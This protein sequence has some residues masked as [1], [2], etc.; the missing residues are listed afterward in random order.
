[1]N[2]LARRAPGVSL[3]QA[4][5]SVKAQTSEILAQSVPPRFNALR[6]KI[7][8]RHKLTV[9]EARGGVDYF[10]RSRFG[11]PLYA[12][13]GL[14]AA[15][16][17]LAG[18]NLTSLLLARSLGRAHEVGIRLALGASRAHIAGIFVFENAVLLLAGTALGT[19]AG[20][21][22]VQ[23]VLSRAG[24]AFGN[25]KLYVGMDLRVIAFL[26]AAFL[27]MMGMFTA[28]SVWQATRLPDATKLKQG[29]RGLIASNSIAQKS[30]L[31]VQIALTLALV[32]GAAL[33]GASIRNSYR[34]DLGIEPRN[35][36]TI[37]LAPRPGGYD[38]FTPHPYYRDLVQQIQ[39]L[40]GIISVST[41]NDEPFS[42]SG[43]KDT[44]AL[45]DGARAASETWV[46]VESIGDH[47]FQTLGAKMIAGDDFDSRDDHSP[48]PA[49][50][51]SRSL[52]ERLGGSRDLIGH[53]LRVGTDT[54]YQRVRIKGI[55]S[56]MDL[57]LS[58]LDN[59]K[60]LTVYVD[61]WQNP[62][63]QRYPVLL[64]KTATNSLNAASIRRI[65]DRKGREFVERFETVTSNIDNALVENRFLAYI[66]GAFGLLALAM[67]AVGLFGLL[68]Y[69]MTNRTAE[70][71]IRLA[72]GARQSQIRWLFLR[73]MLI[74]VVPGCMMGLGLIV[75]VQNLMSGLF[76]QASAYDP[77]L[78]GFAVAVL[79]GTA[80]A[81]AWLPVRRASRIDPAAA[82]RHE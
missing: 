56:D 79:A 31:A 62:D 19:L 66:S 44:A 11:E 9:E 5:A 49:V 53:H 55:A 64:V 59:T 16:L 23:I 17:L 29:G 28:A 21:W 41:S 65:V 15:I 30:L 24:Q 54:K 35:V 52:A 73:Q 77:R 46:Q 13:L 25:L 1:V 72:L 34:I 50:I 47:F 38:H 7:Y 32:A 58:N 3:A 18:V 69:Q 71:G 33:F 76:Y 78:L 10:L 68:S 8:L 12:I 4:L 14:C 63:F 40:P 67:A 20:I 26:I 81:A 60:P 75:V 27:L 42:T 2:V 36:W 22:A 51:L 74:V 70:V 61:F 45:L 37:M 6:R 57:D 82:L 43:Y 80:L 39:S 48:E